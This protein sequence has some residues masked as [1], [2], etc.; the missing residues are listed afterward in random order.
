M[1]RATLKCL[2]VLLTFLCQSSQMTLMFV[3]PPVA[4][5]LIPADQCSQRPY[6]LT[7]QLQGIWSL[8]LEVAWHW[9]GRRGRLLMAFS[10][11]SHTPLIGDNTANCGVNWQLEVCSW[12]IVKPP[13]SWGH[14]RERLSTSRQAKV[15]CYKY[16]S[17]PKHFREKLQGVLLSLHVTQTYLTLE[18]LKKIKKSWR[19]D[20]TWE[21]YFMPCLVPLDTAS[22]TL[23]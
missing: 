3:G 17:K 5:L 15:Y 11:T 10:P 19:M 20:F 22:S 23:S 18:T 2:W 1:V 14:V 9:T 12:I 16:L 13:S 7:T 6:L 4:P 8:A 21:T